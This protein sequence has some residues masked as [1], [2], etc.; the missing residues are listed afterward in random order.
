MNPTEPT[1]RTDAAILARQQHTARLLREVTDALRQMRRDGTRVTVRGV[2]HRAGVSR[3]FLYENSHARRLVDDAIRASAET[4]RTERAARH[5]ATAQDTSWRERA[6]NAESALTAANREV[7]Q[8]RAQIAELM[9]RLRD[10]EHSWSHDGVQRLTSENT[11]LKQRIRQ[12]DETNQALD[13]RLK[14][15]RSN[16][17]FLDR[18]IADLESQLLDPGRK[19]PATSTDGYVIPARDTPAQH[20]PG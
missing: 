11:T 4:G 2:A 18:R 17:R 6:L 20:P 12:L 3:T 19:L 1:A 7:L 5:D 14:A 9:G 13:E 16:T 8:H 10:L 15:A